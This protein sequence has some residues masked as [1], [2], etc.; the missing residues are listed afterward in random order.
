MM[1]TESNKVLFVTAALLLALAPACSKSTG[2]SGNANPTPASA[3]AAPTAPGNSSRFVNAAA[4]ETQISPGGSADVIVDVTVKKGYHVN[5]NPPTFSYLKATELAIT[6]GDG[7]VVR[8]VRYPDAITRKFAFADQ[9]LAV[10]EGQMEIKASIKADPKTSAGSHTLA[11]KVNV[12][13]CDDQVCYPPGT[14]DL[15]LSIRV[16]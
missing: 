2:E 13:A 3:P 9:P 5:A 8:F 15:P 4:N 11:A 16:K 12:Q 10:Y 7:M 14:I 1:K 6:S